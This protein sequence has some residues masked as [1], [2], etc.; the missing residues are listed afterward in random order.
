MTRPKNPTYKSNYLPFDFRNFRAFRSFS[1]GKG[2]E[3]MFAQTLKPLI[4]HI[5]T[6]S[7][8]LLLV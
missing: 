6:K 8:N 4:F 1:M 7:Q 3:N 5:L 2:Y